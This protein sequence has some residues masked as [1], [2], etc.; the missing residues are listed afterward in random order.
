MNWARAVIAGLVAGI[1]TNLASWLFHG[2]LLASTYTEHPIFDVEP[3]NPLYFFLVAIVI[4]IMAAILFARTRDC[5]AP[6]LKG[7]I[8]FGFFLGLV[9]FFS[10]FYNPLVLAGFP[11]FLAWYWGGINLINAVLGGAVLGLL[12]KR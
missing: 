7:G 3:A 11:Y 2:F 12:Y 9:A 10:S 6:G 4:G 1:V 8:T 5:W